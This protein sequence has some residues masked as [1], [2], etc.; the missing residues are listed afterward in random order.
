MP[1]PAHPEMSDYERRAWRTLTAPAPIEPEPEA[2]NRHGGFFDVAKARAR[3]VVERARTT[4]VRIPGAEHTRSAVDSALQKAVEG[5]HTTFVERGLHSVTPVKVFQTF[6]DEGV[7]VEGYDDIRKLDLRV[8]DQTVPWRKERYV[9]LAASQGVATSLAITGAA[10][11]SAV[12]GGT[13]LGV[14]AGAVV[15]DVTAVLTGMGRIVALVAAHYGYDVREPEE[16]VFASG[17]LAFSTAG[18][19]AEKAGALAALSRLT[20]DMMRSAT[21]RRL[22][23]HQRVAVIEQVVTSLGLKL[24]QKKLAQV[25]PIAG[26]VVNG[27]LNAQI[28]HRTFESAQRVYRLRFLTEKYDLDPGVWE[29]DVIDAEVGGL[30]LVDE[31]VE[32][33]LSLGAEAASTG[34]PRTPE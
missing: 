18:N 10:V 25:V 3:D 16:Q 27:S 4:V 24:A 30:P 19:A 31:L 22:E 32:R 17:V 12:S 2:Q 11:S 34:E 9:L 23:R 20:G 21:W 6:T 8:C 15:V 7:V 29:P 5:L 14:A 26:A 13:T 28:A 33:Q 1:R